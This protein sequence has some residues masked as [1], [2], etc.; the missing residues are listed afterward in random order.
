M[1]DVGSTTKKP[2]AYLWQQVAAIVSTVQA[3]CPA[4]GRVVFVSG[5]FNIVHPGHMRLL[6]FAAA[7]GEYLVVGINP[8]GVGETLVPQE[9][10]LES[11]RAIGVVNYA[12][13]LPVAPEDLIRFLKP[14]IVVQG[15][16]H[17]S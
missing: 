4:G 12:A 10:R 6:N 5:N 14:A 1:N 16:E 8:D 2:V 9:L 7:C 11:V 13:I 15:K 17:E 3:Q